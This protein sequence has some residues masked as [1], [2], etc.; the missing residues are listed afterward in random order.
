M[1]DDTAIELIREVSRLASVV[2]DT[3]HRLFGNGQPGIIEIHNK[4]L[5]DLEGLKDRG[6]G[7]TWFL[8]IITTLLGVLESIHLFIGGKKL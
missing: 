2:D 8:G 5:D 3:H 6:I 7:I 1:T 4:R